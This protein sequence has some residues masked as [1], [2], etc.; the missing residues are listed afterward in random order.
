MIRNILIAVLAVALVLALITLHCVQNKLLYNRSTVSYLAKEIRWLRYE[1]DRAKAR[2]AQLPEL[3]FLAETYQ[4]NVPNTY[5]VA[6]AAYKHGTTHGVSPYLVMAVAHRESAFNPRAVSSVGAVGIMQVMPSVWKLDRA[7]MFDID[8]NV[9]QGTL[10]LQHYLRKHPG[11]VGRA[12]FAY[13][14][15][16]VERHDF[17]YPARVLESKYFD[18]QG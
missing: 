5:A 12:L 4:A 9:E 14:G 3:Q 15:G 1:A 16:N 6:R 7:Q 11:D 8:Y 17:S 13:W 18:A 2:V 10:I